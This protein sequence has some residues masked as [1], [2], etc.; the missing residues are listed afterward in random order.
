VFGS[1]GKAHRRAAVVD[2]R[3]R[4]ARKMVVN[5]TAAQF[6]RLAANVAEGFVNG[7]RDLERIYF[8]E[9]Q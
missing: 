9:P 6:A 5:C 2:A 4:R 7:S 8:F 1:A 3:W